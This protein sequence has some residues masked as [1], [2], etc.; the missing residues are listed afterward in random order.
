MQNLQVRLH[1]DEDRATDAADTYWCLICIRT[2]T[3]QTADV[4]FVAVLVAILGQLYEALFIGEPL[5][6]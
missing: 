4:L 1:P 3:M 2:Q 5:K 6:P